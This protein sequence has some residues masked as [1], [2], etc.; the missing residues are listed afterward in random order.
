MVSIRSNGRALGGCE[1]ED[2]AK[3]ESDA[4]LNWDLSRRKDERSVYYE[5]E[6]A[7]T[8]R[9]GLIS[10]RRANNAIARAADEAENGQP[11]TGVP[12][13]HV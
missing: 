9:R 12:S 2:A 5:S 1:R 3:R 8:R 11:G 4:K 13:L 6:P 7:L 10:L